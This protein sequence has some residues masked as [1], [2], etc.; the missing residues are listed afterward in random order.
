MVDSSIIKKIVIVGG[1]TSGW[2]AAMYLNRFLKRQDCEIT[3][4]ESPSIE[5]IGVGEATIPQLVRFIRNLD[6]DEKEFMQECH[7]TYKL[8]IKFFDWIRK[9]HAYWHPFGICGGLID[10]IDLYHF[11][12]KATQTG[13]INEPYS[14][15]SLQ[16]LAADMGKSPC[17]IDGTSQIMDAGAY[18]YHLDAAA[19]AD[20][21]KG[22][23]IP[24]GVK[25]IYA[26]VN[27]VLVN[28]SGYIT[29][30]KTKNEQIITAD[31]FI[32]CTGF[33]GLLIEKTLGDSFVDWSSYLFCDKAV[34][35][36]LNR[37]E[38]IHPFTRATALDAGWCWQIPL[39]NRLGCGYVYSSSHIE[40]ENAAQELLNF[41]INAE[42]SNKEPRFLSMRVGHRQNFWKGNCIS[43]G[44][45]AGFIEPLESTG[46]FFIQHGLELLMDY[47]PDKEPNPILIDTYNKRMTK[48]FEEIR[49]FIMLHYLI[50]QREDTSFWQ[51][52]CDIGL[53]DTLQTMLQ[54]Y[55]EAG[56]LEGINMWLFPEASYFHILSGGELL[57]RR[58]WPMINVSDFSKARYI[59]NKMKQRNLDTANSLPSY[60]NWLESTRRN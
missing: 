53:P 35:L 58:P 2:M 4:I 18:A 36:P 25:H 24:S 45:A 26:D 30:V 54:M 21:L 41:T 13:N 46:I 11:W 9:D 60:L 17:P 55:T 29:H 31:L 10:N 40:D 22:K 28:D 34:V 44:L 8:G 47:F 49:D 15:Y 20:Y 48:A 23:A 32:D 56:I 1:G 57:P 19:F 6:L 5:T 59:M 38:E 52:C 51:D 33:L 12:V 27:Q 43:L 16:A 37:K 7:A 42:T 50:S 3:L 39:I 14:A